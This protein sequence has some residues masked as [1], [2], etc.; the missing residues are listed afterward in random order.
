MRIPGDPHQH[1]LRRCIGCGGDGCGNCDGRGY[2]R[3]ELC[4]G[5]GEPMGN[6]R[7]VWKR[8]GRPAEW[9]DACRR[10]DASRR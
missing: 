9:W 6:F 5:C 3:P 8:L 1:A 2:F 10:W 7:R 4:E